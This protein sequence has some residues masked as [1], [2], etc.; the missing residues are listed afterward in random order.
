MA[1]FIRKRSKKAGLPPGTLVY[2]GDKAPVTP[3]I[4][5]MDYDEK[6]LNETELPSFD[7]CLAYKNKPTT[8]W[9][10]V[11]GISHIPNVEKLGECFNLHPLVLEDILNTDQRPKIEDYDD[12]LFIVLRAIRY[13]ETLN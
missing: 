1:R 8:T 9:I 4:T 2:T 7:A 12:Y 5:V 11:N 10:N 13:D 3:K 6:T